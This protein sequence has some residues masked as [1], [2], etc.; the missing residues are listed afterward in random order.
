MWSSLSKY[1]DLAL[2]FLRLGIGSLMIWLKG[3]PHLSGGV[4]Q[5][6]K[7]G[8]AMKQVE[9]TFFPEVWGFIAAFAES[10]GCVFLILGLFFRPSALLLFLTMLIA[11][12]MEARVNS[13]GSAH[14]AMNL[15]VL[16]FA[17]LFIGPGKYSVDKG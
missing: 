16:F 1:N 4:K 8:N 11:A 15:A 6:A 3:W 17:L 13:W 14:H 9:I 7:L 5:W 10:V 2:L 12:I